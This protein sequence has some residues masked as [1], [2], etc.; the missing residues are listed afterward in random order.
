VFYATEYDKESYQL[1][2][3]NYRIKEYLELYLKYKVF[4]TLTNQVTDESFNQLK[5]KMDYYKALSDEAY[6]IDK[7]EIHKQT[8]Y[9]KQNRIKENLNRLNMYELPQGR[10]GLWGRNGYR[11]KNNL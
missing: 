5:Y 9:Q 8:A 1:I 6:I 11:Y 10:R 4:E 7:N 2:P 3:D